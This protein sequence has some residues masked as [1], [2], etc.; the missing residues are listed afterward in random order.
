MKVEVCP[1]Q[2]NVPSKRV[3]S[4]PHGFRKIVGADGKVMFA[5]PAGARIIPQKN[6]TKV[7]IILY[8]TLYIIIWKFL[9][10]NILS[11]QANY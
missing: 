9:P 1:F 8:Y 10:F 11:Y 7:F 5:L 4:M 6:V 2:G 3:I